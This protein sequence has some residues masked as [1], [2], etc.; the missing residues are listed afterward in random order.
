MNEYPDDLR[1]VLERIDPTFGRTI[2]CD[3]G[4]WPL[5]VKMHQEMAAID[6]DY[7]IY[8]IKEK[9]GGL[10]FYFAPSGPLFS[11]QMLDIANYYERR[12]YS[13][14]ETTGNPGVLMRKDGR[15]KTLNKSFVS[16]GWEVVEEF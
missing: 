2:D 8:Q 11:P 7:R 3:K 4:W 16:D 10:R 12:S 5:I 9:F 6:P 15:L 1:P 14:C 13:T